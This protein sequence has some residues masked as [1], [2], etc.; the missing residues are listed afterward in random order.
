MI[1]AYY[2]LVTFLAQ[3]FLTWLV[4]DLLRSE[5]RTTVEALMSRNAVEFK[6]VSAPH[7]PKLVP[8]PPADEDDRPTI[9]PFGL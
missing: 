5:H 1:P 6:A 7:K 3:A 2:L 8:S 4:A 9:R